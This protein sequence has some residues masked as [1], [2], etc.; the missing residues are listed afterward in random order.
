MDVPILT[1]SGYYD[2]DQPGALAFY[3]G[4]LRAASP[5]DRSRHFL[6]L[7]PWDHG[8]TSSPNR[9]VNGL[10]FGA[11]S[12]V[13]ID[14]LHVDW[15]DWTLKD[16]SRPDFLKERVTYYVP[17]PGAETWKYADSLEAV[18]GERRALFLTS[19]G[20][21]ANDVFASGRLTEQ[22]QAA[23]PDR[24]LDDP[25][26]V[27]PAERESQLSAAPFT[28]QSIVLD[29]GGTGLVYH[30]EPFPAATEI[31]GQVKLSLWMSLDVPDADFL[32][33]LFE[34]R[35]D[36]SSIFLAS[37][38]LRARYRE[39]LEKA[40][41]VTPGKAERYD[42][43]GFAWFARRLAKGSR[44]RLAVTALNSLFFEKNYH[45]GGVVADE[46]GKD[47]RPAHVT[48]WHDAEHPSALTIPLGR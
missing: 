1:I 18:E 47:A 11:A 34:V 13:D 17:G 9:E 14:K 6:V 38:M 41:L 40:R 45:T 46:S 28:D 7:G 25:L 26:D 15:Y 48:V 37:D 4:H 27:H 42:F 22:L 29:L 23:P 5:A 10:T 33:G 44:L 36:G 2:G 32:V 39:S 20:G 24:Y 31:A 21:K 30:S 16:G 19:D 8:G 3:Q 35:P 43:D 12:L